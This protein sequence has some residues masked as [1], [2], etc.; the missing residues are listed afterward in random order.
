MC[1]KQ[2]FARTMSKYLA[3][4]IEQFNFIKFKT[5]AANR[6]EF[7]PKTVHYL[8]YLPNEES[9]KKLLMIQSVF[10]FFLFHSVIL[11]LTKIKKRASAQVL[12]VIRLILLT[13]GDEP[14]GT[15]IPSMFLN[16][17]GS[18]IDWKYNTEPERKACLA[19]PEQRCFWPRGKVMGGT[20]VINGM[21]YIRGNKE[22][23]ILFW[24]LISFIIHN[25]YP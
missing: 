23:T 12:I 9:E 8:D 7:R 14:S 15:Q 10:I 5:S 6:E 22:G 18:D 17:I 4:G 21:M 16:F 24:T 13:G 3:N 19:S 25:I 11:Y 1:S 2:T 20:S